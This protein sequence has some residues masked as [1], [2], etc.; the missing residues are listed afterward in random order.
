MQR[1]KK[2]RRRRH[3]WL[4]TA[5]AAGCGV[6]IVACV[7]TIVILLTGGRRAPNDAQAMADLSDEYALT[8]ERQATAEPT[9]EPAPE[10]TAA[11]GAEMITETV[12][13]QS[14]AQPTAQPTA[15]P[16]AAPETTTVERFAY[17]PVVQASSI[18]DKRIAITVD[19]CFQ[20][21]NLKTIADVASA[22]GGRLTLFPIGKNVVRDGMPEILQDCVFNRG[23]EIENHTFNHARIFR[24]PA[25]QM[26]T[27]IWQQR[28]AVSYALGVNYRQHFFRLMGGDGYK[29]QR[30]HAYLKQLGFIG[31]ADWAV[32][33]S[34]T[35]LEGIKSS[36]KPG[37]IYLFHTTDADT[38]KL[39]EFIPYAVSQGYQLV[40]LNNLFGLPE[41]EISD[42]STF[43]QNMPDPEPYVEDYLEMK[44][45]DYSWSVVL[46]QRRLCE[47]GFLD[48][49]D[50]VNG[51]AADGV[52]G[53]GTVEAIKQFQASAGL[54]VT[55]TAD[56]ETQKRLLGESA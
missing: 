1:K 18:S 5:I 30:T 16:T 42:L 36:L 3:N 46:I 21:E 19:D 6:I 41:N 15:E 51:N 26:A 10:A 31:I 43:D 37:N 40:T 22:N 23:F 7:V 56:T 4:P 25:D 39:K 12:T 35:S 13:E 17:L 32:S 49:S 11:P 34:D 52:F 47:L 28:A 9:M 48:A 45:G 44:K 38:K 20:M 14:A 8:L 2:Y 24:L 50:G 33:G 27:E 29:D 53:T 54:P 55:G